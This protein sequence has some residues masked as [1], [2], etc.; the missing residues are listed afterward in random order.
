MYFCVFG[1][2]KLT[3]IILPQFLFYEWILK[4]YTDFLIIFLGILMN[5]SYLN[6]SV[7]LRFFDIASFLH[8]KFTHFFLV[9]LASVELPLLSRF[10]WYKDKISC[11][12]NQCHLVNVWSKHSCNECKSCA[13]SKKLTLFDCKNVHQIQ[14]CSFT[15]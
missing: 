13:I 11:G 10:P 7:S 5:C 12:V 4:S 2:R 6:F 1:R 15:N 14:K 9:V 3:K 8:S